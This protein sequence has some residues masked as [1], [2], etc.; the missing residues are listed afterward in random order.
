M[1][2]LPHTRSLY[3]VYKY[4]TL[5]RCIVIMN[6]LTCIVKIR[7]A[8]DRNVRT[9]FGWEQVEGTRCGNVCHFRNGKESVG[10][11]S[12]QL[13][14]REWSTSSLL[15]P[16]LLILCPSIHHSSP[17][18]V[19]LKRCLCCL[20]LQCWVHYLSHSVWGLLDSDCVFVRD[21]WHQTLLEVRLL[22]IV[23]VV[24]PL[25]PKHKHT[26]TSKVA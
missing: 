25:D 11:R 21:R 17:Q 7:A 4:I 20:I 9:V 22:A 5:K 3:A 2:I 13:A 26:C 12:T 18:A 19:N 1:L 15:H 6:N 8:K 24:W 14:D 16:S 10:T 23:M